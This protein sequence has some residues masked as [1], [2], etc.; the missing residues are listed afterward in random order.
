MPPLLS[1]EILFVDYVYHH[2]NNLHSTTTAL[3]TN[4][5][6]TAIDHIYYL[7]LHHNIT[8]IKSQL[9]CHTITE[10]LPNTHLSPLGHF[11]FFFE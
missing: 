2:Q 7:Q 1:E 9:Y 6:Y 11:F 5:I 10:Y 8:T 4:D 3:V